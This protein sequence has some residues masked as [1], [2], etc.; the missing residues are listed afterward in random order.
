M[1]N[2]V[3]VAHGFEHWKGQDLVIAAM[4]ASCYITTRVY[5]KRQNKPERGCFNMGG[6]W[7]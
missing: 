2:E 1:K 7:L 6:P 5:M 3:H 4:R